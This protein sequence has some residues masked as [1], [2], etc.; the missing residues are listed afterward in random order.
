MGVRGE[1]TTFSPFSDETL[2]ELNL[3]LNPDRVSVLRDG[4]SA[5]TPYL[6]GEDVTRRANEVFGLGNWGFELLG[7]PTCVETVKK[8]DG[9]PQY[10]VWTAW[11]RLHIRNAM[12]IADLGTCV[13]FGGGN[14]GLEMAIKG[15]VTDAMK[16]CLKQLGDQFGLVLYDK[17]VDSRELRKQWAD[18]LGSEPSGD[19]ATDARNHEQRDLASEADGI[20]WEEFYGQCKALAVGLKSICASLGH[21]ATSPTEGAEWLNSHGPQA[22]KEWLEANPDL[23]W[24]N[25]VSRLADQ[26]AAS[27]R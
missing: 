18:A 12:P 14:G 25:L 10:E 6:E 16:R 11:G 27:Q 13:R 9:S 2:H 8:A 23:N 15:C 3:P 26:K 7:H 17:T 21:N 19:G 1:M 20:V 22:L 5:G 4:P 24:S